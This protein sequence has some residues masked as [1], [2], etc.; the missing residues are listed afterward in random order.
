VSFE[1]ARR[2][3]FVS[4]LAAAPDDVDVHVLPTGDPD[5]PGFADSSAL[6]YRDTSR[7]ADRIKLAW[8]ATAEYLAAQ[9]PAAEGA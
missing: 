1:I 6:R 3:R 4:E 9:V 2:H 7:V 5:P 8:M